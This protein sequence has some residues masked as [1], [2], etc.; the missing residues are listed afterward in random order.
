M[1]AMTAP[2]G[3]E[4]VRTSL[5]DGR[6]RTVRG[7]WAVP[8]VGA[9]DRAWRPSVNHGLVHHYFGSKDALL[10]AVLDELAAESAP[11][12]R[13]G[14]DSRRWSRRTGLSVD[15]AAS[16]RICCSRPA[17]L[18]TC[19]PLSPPIDALAVEPPIARASRRGMRPSGPRPWP[20]SCSDGSCSSRSSTRAAGTRRWSSRRRGTR[21]GYQRLLSA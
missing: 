2:R 4:A 3:A 18:P 14:T 11:K 6:L 16:S 21:C 12:S 13:S 9:R 17:I 10:R 1:S 5:V 8:R 20:P 19:R 15:T 7:S